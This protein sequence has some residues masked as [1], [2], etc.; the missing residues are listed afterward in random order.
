[1]AAVRVVSDDESFPPGAPNPHGN[2]RERYAKV[3][4]RLRQ[5]LQR[6][7]SPRA[8]RIRTTVRREVHPRRN[9]ARENRAVRG[10]QSRSSRSVQ[11]PSRLALVQLLRRR[12]ELRFR[13]LTVDL[14]H[15]RVPG[16]GT[17]LD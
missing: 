15:D 17:W 10:F 13:S 7:A 12:P 1:M 14:G 5:T 2:S 16:T 9:A 3:E 4:W 8:S 6:Q 11:A